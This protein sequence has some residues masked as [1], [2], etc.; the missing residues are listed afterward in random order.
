MES[1]VD[2][3]IDDGNPFIQTNINGTY[4]LVELKKTYNEKVLQ[5]CTNINR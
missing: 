1:H 5:I 4:N 2:N 3:S